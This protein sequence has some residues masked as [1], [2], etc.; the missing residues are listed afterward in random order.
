MSAGERQTRPYK[1][2]HHL[3]YKAILLYKKKVLDKWSVV[4]IISI[5]ST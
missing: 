3:F 4:S 2:E 5:A 1:L